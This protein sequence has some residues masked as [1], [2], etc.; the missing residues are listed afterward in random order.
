MKDDLINDVVINDI[1]ETI[2]KE[3]MAIKT[4]NQ[5]NGIELNKRE[6]AYLL[7]GSI[8]FHILRNN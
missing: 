3:Q 1:F 7:S 5:I 4:R 8:L 2:R 6:D